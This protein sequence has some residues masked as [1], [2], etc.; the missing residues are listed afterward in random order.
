MSY[1]GWSNYETWAVNLWLSNDELSYRTVME[2][3][4]ESRAGEDRHDYDEPR[5][6]L[7][8]RLKETLEEDMPDLGASMWSDL[9]RAGFAEVDWT[10]IA[11]SW[12]AGLAE[13]RAVQG[14]AL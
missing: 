12:L 13:W 11:E 1:E 8:D 2:W 4:R 3:A 6:R 5:F 14:R 10:E 9:L 7:A